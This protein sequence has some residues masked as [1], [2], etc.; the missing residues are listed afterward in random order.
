ML[1]GRKA[2][3]V[4]F[5]AKIIET[6]KYSIIILMCQ[7]VN[8]IDRYGFILQACLPH[9]IN[10]E[11]STVSGPCHFC[12]ISGTLKDVKQK[13]YLVPSV[14]VKVPPKEGYRCT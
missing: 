2:T 9:K 10:A 8:E 14:N 1:G 4:Y 11:S 6:T 5:S 13:D 7:L 12:G 3:M